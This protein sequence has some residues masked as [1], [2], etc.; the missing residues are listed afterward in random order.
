MT[1]SLANFESYR[2]DVSVQQ[3]RTDGE[4]TNDL[5][6]K[7]AAITE[8]NCELQIAAINKRRGK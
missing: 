5:F 4:S 2:F 1:F 3:A 8:R 7:I 6:G